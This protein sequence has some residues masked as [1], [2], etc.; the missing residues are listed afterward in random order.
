MDDLDSVADLLDRLKTLGVGLKID[1]FGTGYASLKC[2]NRLPFDVLKIDRS[3]V[4]NMSA[5]DGTGETIRTILLLAE[6]LGMEVVAEG[7]EKKEQLIELQALHCDY[8]QGYYFSPPLEPSA[9]S[10]LIRKSRAKVPALKA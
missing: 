6:N 5:G 9:L 3:F 10:D 2:L 1:D 8:G 4:V 7:I